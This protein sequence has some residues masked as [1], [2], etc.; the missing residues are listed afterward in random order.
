AYGCF[1]RRSAPRLTWIKR[2]FSA[3]GPV[4]GEGVEAAYPA[5]AAIDV[6]RLRGRFLLGL[7]PRG[8]QPGPLVGGDAGADP[9]Q[10]RQRRALA[11]ED[12]RVPLLEADRA[13]VV[14]P[15]P[16]HHVGPFQ[17]LPPQ[18]L[19]HDRDRLVD[20]AGQ[21]GWRGAA[22]L[23]RD[24]HRD[25]DVG[26]Q[27][28]GRVH[29]YRA[30]YAAVDV[31]AAADARRLEHAWHAAGGAHRLAGIA[32]HEHHPVAGV[33]ARGHGGEGLAQA[34]DRAAAHL[35]VDVVLQ[36]LSLHQPAGKQADVAQRRFVQRRRA[37]LQRERI[38]AGGVQRPDHAPGAGA[39]DHVGPDAV[40]LEHLDHADVGEALGRAAAQGQAYAR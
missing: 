6:G 37:L 15:W 40:G 8:L 34:L 26:A 27:L 21:R 38:D 28:A 36:R 31:A 17:L 2:A 19:A 10:R 3:A 25:D 33:Q 12:R 1:R 13:D 5:V 22:G 18:G 9:R 7:A 23:G 4:P 16:D 29:R 14:H 35:A 39:G 32:A 24:V 20:D 30:D 11:L